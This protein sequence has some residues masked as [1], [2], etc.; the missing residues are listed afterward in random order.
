MSEPFEAQGKL[1]V[2]PPKENALADSRAPVPKRHPGRKR[3]V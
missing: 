3:R 1:K 2:R